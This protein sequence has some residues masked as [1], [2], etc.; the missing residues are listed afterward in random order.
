MI[1]DAARVCMPRG[2]NAEGIVDGSLRKR[3]SNCLHIPH[4]GELKTSRAAAARYFWPLMDN[5]VQQIVKDCEVCLTNSRSQAVE[6]PPEKDEFAEYPMQ[7]M[8]YDPF[9]FG[10]DTWLILVD[11]YSNFSFA[12]KLGWTGG[13]EKVIHKLRK[14]FF[15]HGF[16]EQLRTDDGQEYR[17]SF[18]RWCRRAGIDATHLS[19]YN[20][21]GNARAEKKDS[22]REESAP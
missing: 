7:K 6:P 20:S 11:W 17:Q 1:L 5:E 9:H 12:K 14:I 15:Q 3:I 16:C 13:T 21:S 4:L 2:T 10:S 18:Q 8:S 22:K 19:A